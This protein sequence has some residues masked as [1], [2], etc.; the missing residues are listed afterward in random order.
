MVRAY[1]DL[2]ADFNFLENEISKQEEQVAIK[3]VCAGERAP[4]GTAVIPTFCKKLPNK[5]Q[6]K[7][8]SVLEK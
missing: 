7:S 2:G 6:Q 4:R 8:N 1:K 3:C 5:Q